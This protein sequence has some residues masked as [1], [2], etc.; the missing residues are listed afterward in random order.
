MYIPCWK[1]SNNLV[2]IKLLLYQGAM[3]NHSFTKDTRNAL[4]FRH[5]WNNSGKSRY[6]NMEWLSHAGGGHPFL[7]LFVFQVS[8]SASSDQMRQYF[9]AAL[10]SLKRHCR[11]KWISNF[12]EAIMTNR[13]MTNLKPAHFSPAVG[14]SQAQYIHWHSLAASLP[15]AGNKNTLT[16]TLI[17]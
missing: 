7:K 11:M 1:Q 15:S 4:I 13:F 10:T 8:S 16:P 12:K 9:N 3:A 2:V 5:S 6:Y 17:F 14:K